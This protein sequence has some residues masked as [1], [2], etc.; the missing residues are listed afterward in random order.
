MA[1]AISNTGSTAAGAAGKIPLS[2]AA[3]AA[4]SSEESHMLKPLL[5]TVDPDHYEDYLNEKAAAADALFEAVAPGCPSAE[6]HE[7][8]RSHF[9][10]RAEFAV[11]HKG[12]EI[13]YAM[14]EKNGRDRIRHEVESFPMAHEAINRAMDLLRQAA[15]SMPEIARNLFEAEFLCNLAG[16]VVVTL[17][18]HRHPDEAV[19][20]EAARGLIGFFAQNGLRASV[21]ARARKQKI[22]VP[23]DWVLETICTDDGGKFSLYEAE[24]CFTQPNTAVA[25][26]MVSFARECCR[27]QK[28]RDLLEL[29]CGS[30][31][32]TVC[33]AE[34][35]SKALATEVARVPAQIAARNIKKNG[36]TNLKTARLSAEEMS[37]ALDGVRPFHRLQQID[38]NL[39]D[40][41]FSTLLIDPPRSGLGD[42]MSLA[43]TARFDRVVYI[44]CNPQTQCEDLKTLLKTHR[45][46]RRA[47]FDQFPYTPHLESGVLLVRK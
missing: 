19:W 6:I 43:F 4:H 47:Y 16:D 32:F 46:A 7:S 26:K 37:Q 45:I 38:C 33:L 28:D 1:A 39:A 24:G 40:Y 15:P 23:G 17:D 14:F 13:C 2:G 5:Y 34:L 10:N 36:I 21:V 25:C 35:F 42:E 29:Y 20:S 18:Y 27:D 9:R 3:R 11:F 31:T 41:D 44:S 12:D 30:G 8:R 22:A